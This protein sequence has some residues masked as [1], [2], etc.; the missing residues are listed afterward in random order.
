MEK[1]LDRLRRWL[2]GEPDEI[3][4]WMTIWAE[5]VLAPQIRALREPR[6]EEALFLTTHSFVQA[7]MDAVYEIRGPQATE[8]YQKRFVDGRRKQD[9][10]S[11]IS[12]QIHRMRN[13]IAHQIYSAET[14]DIGYDYGLETGWA[15]VGGSLRLNPSIYADRFV[16][17][18]EQR[19]HLWHKW[20]TRLQAVHQKYRY[21]VK[22]L[23]LP[24]NDGLHTAVDTLCSL[25]SLSALR[26][27]ERHLRRQFR[28][29]YGV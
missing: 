19:V 17:G 26:P 22:W 12:G 25:P 8:L 20:L 9:K 11:L 21:I 27:A 23:R 14:H 29:R 16:E 6:F 3:F 24:R 4:G 28:T 5:N 7:F 15:Q 2:D 13:V 10:F 1:R 18:L